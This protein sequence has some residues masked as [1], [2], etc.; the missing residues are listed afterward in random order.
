MGKN[1]SGS[2]PLI[3]GYLPVRLTLPSN[4]HDSHDDTFFYVKEHF[5][6]DKKTLFIANAPVVP[7]IQTQILLRSLLGRYG[8]VERVTVIENPRKDPKVAANLSLSWTTKSAP[9]FFSTTSC[10][11]GEGKFAHV[12]FVSPKEMKKAMKG[13]EH[14][15]AS[16]K[17]D[18]PGLTMERLEIQTLQDET[19]RKQ[20]EGV[21]DCDDDVHDDFMPNERK[22]TGMLVVAERYQKSHLALSREVL[23]EE[24]NAVMESFEDM[25][26]RDRLA[27]QAAK[28]EPD[29]D[30]FV[31]VTYSAQKLGSKRDLEE[32]ITTTNNRRGSKRRRKKKVGGTE[33]T[34][35]YRFQQRETRKKDLQ[36]LRKRFEEDLVKIKRMKEERQYRPF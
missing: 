32:G 14:V 29:E 30:G 16:R 35:F 36:D 7:G 2:A 13:L 8:Q 17:H 33:L 4:S 9:S 3:K 31:A 15:M 22:V 6:G 34:D 5:A 11:S 21:D 25:E 1:S 24:C 23:L 18:F 28:N 10:T 12:V 19:Q 27:R 26:E 20:S